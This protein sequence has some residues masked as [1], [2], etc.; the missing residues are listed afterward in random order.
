MV[1]LG[2]EDH[3]G[4]ELGRVGFKMSLS[5]EAHKGWNPNLQI[6]WPELQHEF[7]ADLVVS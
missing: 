3:A 1:Q 4:L 7:C 2:I 6:G 5:H